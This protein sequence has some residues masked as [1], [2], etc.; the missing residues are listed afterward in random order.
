MKIIKYSTMLLN[1]AKKNFRKYNDLLK[2]MGVMD[3]KGNIDLKDMKEKINKFLSEGE[4][5]KKFIEEFDED[6]KP[7]VEVEN[8]KIKANHL[9]PSQDA[10]F[11]DHILS[12][13][14]VNDYDREQILSGDLKDHDIL[15]SEDDHIIDGHH[16]WAAANILNPDCKINCTKVKLPIK[17]ALP[18]I[19]SILEASDKI[20]L[21]RSGDY[22]VNIYDL[23][24]WNKKRLMKKM[25]AIITKTIRSGVDLGAEKNLKSEEAW[26]ETNES[27]ADINTDAGKYFYKNI[28]KKLDLKKHPLKYMRKNLKKMSVPKEIFGP[29]EE[30]PKIKEKDAKEYL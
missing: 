27:L 20:T 29:R 28:K 13:L 4:N 25:N 8:V 22:R 2:N 17:Y 21:G 18:L 24:N 14:V 9:K 6:V 15:I 26:K 23:K 10:I 12:R 30:M 3:E 11:L 16:R 19:N 1:E 5:K 7:N